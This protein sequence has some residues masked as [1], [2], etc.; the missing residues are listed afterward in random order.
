MPIVCEICKKEVL[1]AS[2]RKI[3]DKYLWMCEDCLGYKIMNPEFVPERIKEERRKY[4][5]SLIQPFREGTPSKEFA[6]AYPE[7]AK[8]IFK[9]ERPKEVWK[10]DI[11]SDWRKSK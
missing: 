6:E 7:Q 8:K 10:G 9:K 4:A 3:Q 11:P 1:T 2:Y 5:K